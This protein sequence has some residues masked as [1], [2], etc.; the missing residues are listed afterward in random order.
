MRGQSS[1]N[2]PMRILM[3]DD[4]RDL[5]QTLGQSL[6]AL[7]IHVDGCLDGSEADVVLRRHGYDVIVLDLSLPGLSGLEV[8]RRLRQRGDPVPVL[9]LTASGDLEDRVHGLNA[10]ADDYL[11]K[12]FE[13]VELEARLRALHRRNAGALNPVLRVGRLVLLTASRQFL[14]DG[15]RL[16]LPPR[17]HELLEA[18][19]L[20]VGRPISK[21]VLAERLRSSD[22][23]L[24]RDALE[25]YVHRLRRRLQGAGANIRTLRGLG[26]LLEAGDDVSD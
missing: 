12:P 14:V 16:E 13:L 15:R 24:S 20:Q 25:I 26:Y 8:L 9:I 2:V 18:L 17:E 3:I 6:G 4:H 10:G 19:V 11:P 7:E 1:H 22:A 5:V 21:A 23:V